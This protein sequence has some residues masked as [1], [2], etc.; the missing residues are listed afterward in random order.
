M[1][2]DRRPRLK[3][4]TNQRPNARRSML[5]NIGPLHVYLLSL[6]HLLCTAI[7]CCKIKYLRLLSNVIYFTAP[8]GCDEAELS[9][10]IKDLA[11]LCDS[12]VTLIFD[13]ISV[14]NF[15]SDPNMI[16]LSDMYEWRQTII[17]GFN[18]V[19][20]YHR[21]YIIYQSCW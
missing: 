19:G 2:D 8:D 16:D 13:M 7:N 21:C 12:E 10:A 15:T 6:P 14:T 5:Y 3:S 20:N 4:E 11:G 1:S 18:P 9:V 17:D